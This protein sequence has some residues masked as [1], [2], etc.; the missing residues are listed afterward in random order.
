MTESPT[1]MLVID[2]PS[3]LTSHDVVLRVR[4]ILGGK[5]GHT[6]TLD[7]Q[8][9]GVLILCL[10]SATRLARFLQHQDKAYDCLVRFGQA[11]DTYDAEGEPL[12]EAVDPGRI[13]PDRVEEA[14]ERFRGTIQQVP[15]VYS[16]KKVRGQPSYKRARRGE[17]VELEPVEVRVDRLELRGIEGD[18]VRL[19]VACGSG[20]YVRTLA[21]ELGVALGIPAHLAGLRRVSVGPT[22]L[23][24]AID[25]R[26]VEEDDAAAL[27][28]AVLP[29]GEMFPTW[30][31]VV[32]NDRGLETLANGG[33]VE[34]RMVADRI[35]GSEG[36]GV[37]A[38]GPGGWVR[39]LD[40]D[41]RMI[42]ALEV[43]PGGMLQPRI[44]L[45]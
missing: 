22:G 27:A 6:G 4:R 28:A 21:H 31:A 12:G 19:H 11:T 20:F 25:W 16:A 32:L 45:R 43:L 33:V 24:R 9:T 29:A 7:P 3:G 34:P 42:A 2:K 18:S 39:G 35:P 30:P 44:V 13:D 38:A 10:G 8:A 26:L 23:D 5:V 36:T 37:A 40:P 41:G 15:P 1:G 14:L 17:Q